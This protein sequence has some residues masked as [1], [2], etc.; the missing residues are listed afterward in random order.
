MTNLNSAYEQYHLS[1][2]NFIEAYRMV[3]DYVTELYKLPKRFLEETEGTMNYL[4][5][6]QFAPKAPS[7]TDQSMRVVVSFMDQ[8]DEFTVNTIDLFNQ[9]M[10]HIDATEAYMKKAV[11]LN[12]ASP[13]V[14]NT[15]DPAV[16]N[17]L[18]PEVERLMGGLKAI[19]ERADDT[20][21]WLEEL[22]IDWESIQDDIKNAA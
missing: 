7:A 9:H 18:I 20:L 10:K 4:S 21:N 3:N 2:S 11:E 12:N 14:L 6:R 17:A 8:L 16:Y 13:A 1:H 22:E 5:S 19:K 15:A